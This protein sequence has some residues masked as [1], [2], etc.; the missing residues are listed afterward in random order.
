MP[1]PHVGPMLEVIAVMGWFPGSDGALRSLWWAS[2]LLWVL[3]LLVLTIQAPVGPPK[4]L[5]RALPGAAAQ[6]APRSF[7]PGR[8]LAAG[9]TGGVVCWAG[10]A[11]ALA[12]LNTPN[13]AAVRMTGPFQLVHMWW[14]ILVICCGMTLTAACVAAVKDTG[15]LLSGL[16]SAGIAA[17]L[18][19]GGAYLL[20]R[21]DGC[22]GLLNTM[23]NT[24]R[25]W[26]DV[27]AG[28]LW[29]SGWHSSCPSGPWRQDWPLSRVAAWACSGEGAA[30]P[31]SSRHRGRPRSGRL[32]G[33]GSTAPR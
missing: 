17:L 24:C 6:H 25:W 31:G 3:P 10:L 30:E 19:A 20:M 8:L 7:G 2:V 14:P 18:G 9:L 12:H 26:P 1:P 4:W 28:T 33:C 15:W 22:L 29:S 11:M 5:A 23:T 13:P 32:A 16:V 27:V 21:A